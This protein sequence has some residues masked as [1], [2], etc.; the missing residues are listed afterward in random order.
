ML[1]HD[2][3]IGEDVDMLE[4]VS[5]DGD[6]SANFPALMLPESVSAPKC[7]AAPSVAF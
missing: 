4:K 3:R 5:L 6:H 1:N 2:N 7:L